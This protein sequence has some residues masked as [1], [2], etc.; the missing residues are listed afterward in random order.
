M[1][2]LSPESAGS[3]RLCAQGL[4]WLGGAA[5]LPPPGTQE[6]ASS[7]TADSRPQFHL[8]AAHSQEIQ[9]KEGGRDGEKGGGV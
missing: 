1:V 3:S 9:I 5:A 8:R 2:T 7:G 6:L 4:H